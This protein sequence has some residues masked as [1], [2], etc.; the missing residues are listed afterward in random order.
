MVSPW[1]PQND[2]MTHPKLKLFIT[3]GGLNGQNE[4]AYHGV[5]MLVLAI[6]GDH[7]Y[8]AKRGIRIGTTEMID[9]SEV[10]YE[11]LKA[12]L[13]LMLN[14]DEYLKKAKKCGEILQSLPSGIETTLFWVNHVL[15][16]GYDHLQ[17]VSK[18]MPWYRILMLDIA[19]I[20]PLLFFIRRICRFLC[21]NTKRLFTGLYQIF[22]PK[23]D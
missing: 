14:S 8:N 21:R 22:K 7:V 16:F 4:A 15:K 18:N 10:T 1:L 11:S 5:P 12:K 6:Y 23:T 3:H 9:F 19:L 20:F 13:D 2:L 17:P